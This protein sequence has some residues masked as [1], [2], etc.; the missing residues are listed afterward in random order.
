MPWR[1]L[2][3]PVDGGTY[4]DPQLV[5][6]PAVPV[7]RLLDL[8]GKNRPLGSTIF[9][10]VH[11]TSEMPHTEFIRR[12]SAERHTGREARLDAVLSKDLEPWS[13]T[14][15][16]EDASKA[17]HTEDQHEEVLDEKILQANIARLSLIF[18]GDELNDILAA[19]AAIP[20]P[21]RRSGR[22]AAMVSAPRPMVS[23]CSPRESAELQARPARIATARSCA[24]EASF[25]ATFC[26]DVDRVSA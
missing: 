19:S 7:K 15:A 1:H 9:P 24:H 18:H 20:P 5:T 12:V 21:L 2:I 23:V 8:Q 10:P 17:V 14:S 4:I 6:P 16:T 26:K 22:G 25:F 13:F 3:F 11:L